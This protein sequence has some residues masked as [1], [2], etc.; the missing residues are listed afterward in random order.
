MGLGIVLHRWSCWQCLSSG[1]VC[2][3]M[4]AGA[5]RAECWIQSYSLRFCQVR[6]VKQEMGTR[7]WK[8]YERH[9][10]NS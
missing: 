10:F 1:Q 8:V 9:S 7:A 3:H 2:S 4:D 5:E 6:T